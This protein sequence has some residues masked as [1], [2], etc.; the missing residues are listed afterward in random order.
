MWADEVD[1]VAADCEEVM[2]GPAPELP[3]VTGAIEAA[4]MVVNHQP[5]PSL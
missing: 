1:T 3:G 4:G 5:D 2:A